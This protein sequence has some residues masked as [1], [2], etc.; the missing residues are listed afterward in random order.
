MRWSWTLVAVG[1]LLGSPSV[2]FAGGYDTPML[3]S[4]RHLGMGGAAVSY[5]NDPSAIF[6]NPAGL[7]H[8]KKL[9]LM[10]DLSFLVGDIQASP[11]DSED[12][13]S[14]RSNNT[15]APFF[16]VGVAGRIAPYVTA[17]V[18]VY[19]VASAGATFEYPGTDED[20][21][22]TTV[23]DETQLLFFEVSPALALDIPQANL[24]LGVGYRITIVSLDRSR[25]CCQGPLPDNLDIDASGSDFAGFRAGVQYQ[26]IPE[27]QLGLS[28]RH[29]TRTQVDDGEGVVSGAPATDIRTNFV[30]PSRLIFGVRGDIGD[31][32]AS[33][34]V[35]RGF[36]SQNQQENVVVTFEGLGDIPVANVFSW[37]DA[38]TVRAGL[39]YRLLDDRLP[40]RVGYIWDQQT[41]VPAY[42][43]A[44]GTPPAATHVFTLGAGWRQGPWEVNVAYARRQGSGTVVEE[45]LSTGPGG[46]RN[47]AEG[48]RGPCSFCGFPGNY[49]IVLNGIYADF[50]YSFGTSSSDRP[51]V[52]HPFGLGGGSAPVES[53]PAQPAPAQPASV[54]PASVEP[55][56]V[57]P[58]PAEPAPV[59]PAPA[60]ESASEPGI[61]PSAAPAAESSEETP[62]PVVPPGQTGPDFPVA[63]DAENP[64]PP[65]PE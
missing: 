47:L 4:A 16:L 13:T 48:G 59:E 61:T 43:T 8:T 58:A 30:L 20:G 31:F 11:A 51:R 26:P 24:R 12:A 52:R 53:A 55:A 57:E 18:A 54:E 65:A 60:D 64:S 7:G 6:H 29:K 5:V 46:G 25:T 50:S 21:A 42:A 37:Q 38:W 36:N 23:V 32:G 41:S 28:Y 10:G 49:E 22:P 44:F 56:P 15:F 33:V 17:G 35:E 27:L 34:D 45:D 62:E 39:E 63:P 40:V 3:Y 9:T 1:L 19:P 14:I 2:A